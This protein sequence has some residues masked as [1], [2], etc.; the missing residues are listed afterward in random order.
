ML[1]LLRY[2][3]TDQ[4]AFLDQACPCGSAHQLVADVEGRLDDVFSFA[5]G[6]VVHP[7]VFRS[8]LG[9]DAGIVEFQVLQTP[10]GAEVLA[11][12]TPDDPAAAGRAHVAELAQVGGA[13][14]SLQV[15]AVGHL[16]CQQTGKVRRFR[17]LA[18]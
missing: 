11:L 5:G 2:E 4:V 3:I 18:G 9:R 1:P 6:V 13:S 14:P 17:P 8:V 10:T 12:G 15:R 16:P 7:H